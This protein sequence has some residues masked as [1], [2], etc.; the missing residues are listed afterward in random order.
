[1]DVKSSTSSMMQPMNDYSINKTVIKTEMTCRRNRRIIHRLDRGIIHWCYKGA[2][3]K[4]AFFFS[5]V[6]CLQMGVFSFL[7][8]IHFIDFA[9]RPEIK[10]DIN[11]VIQ[12]S[13]MEPMND[14]SINKTVIK[15][16]MTCRRKM[17]IKSIPFIWEDNS[18]TWY[19]VTESNKSSDSE[20]KWRRHMDFY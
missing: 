18:H 14:Y 9:S 13:M 7:S 10:W 15:T 8:P 2:F 20:T 17:A 19:N 5:L 1:M 12:T 6:C 4:N 11:I 16:E 3:N